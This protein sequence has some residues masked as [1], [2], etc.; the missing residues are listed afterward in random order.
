MS[1]E[2]GNA[3]SVRPGTVAGGIV[4]LVVGLTMLLDRAGVLTIEPGRLIAPFVLIGMGAAILARQ[5]RCTVAAPETSSPGRQARHGDGTTAGL[6]FIGL[7]CWLLISQTHMFGL[8]FGT[9]W[10]L[11]LI[12]MGTL[13]AIR[14]WR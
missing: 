2:Q 5:R 10:P 14:G 6:W 7:G 11:L 8:S 3:G 4:L 9:S 13:I 1:A 12:L